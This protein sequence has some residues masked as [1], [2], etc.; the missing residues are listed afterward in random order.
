MSLTSG[1]VET[2]KRSES[3]SAVTR[4][5]LKGTI[6]IESPGQRVNFR[7]LLPYPLYLNVDLA[8]VKVHGLV[9]YLVILLAQAVSL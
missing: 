8:S 7:G 6:L 3:I 2:S 9:L 1:V 5:F 4:G